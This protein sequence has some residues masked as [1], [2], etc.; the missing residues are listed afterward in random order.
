MRQGI[1]GRGSEGEDN[2]VNVKMLVGLKTVIE[3][4]FA[5]EG[6]SAG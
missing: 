5:T 3:L 2:A 4:R 1:G 6:S